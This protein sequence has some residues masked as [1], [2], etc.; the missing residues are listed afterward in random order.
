MTGPQALNATPLTGVSLGCSWAGIGLVFSGPLLLPWVLLG[1]GGFGGFWK[2]IAKIRQYNR[3]PIN[4]KFAHQNLARFAG[5]PSS[6]PKKSG[7]TFG[8]RVLYCLFR[9]LCATIAQAA[10][11]DAGVSTLLDLL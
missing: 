6:G 5:A 11:C 4:A 8:T 7:R 10:E 9:M 2:A 1:S 3:M